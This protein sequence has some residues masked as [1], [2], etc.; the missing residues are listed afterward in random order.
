MGNDG[1]FK[2]GHTLNNGRVISVEH[3]EKLRIHFQGIPRPQEVIQRIRDSMPRGE[4]HWN[5]KGGTTS[6]REKIWA[7]LEYK[8]WRKKIFERDNFICVL[9][10]QKSGMLNADHFPKTMR[11]IIKE[12][13]LITIEDARKCEL[14]WDIRNGRT[15]CLTCHRRTETWG[16]GALK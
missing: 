14:L 11:Q 12:N 1:R 16:F 9:C 6:L 4:K 15:L 2:K 3:R 10:K 5:W 7:R 8:A 13:N